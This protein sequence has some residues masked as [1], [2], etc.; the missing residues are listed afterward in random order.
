MHLGMSCEKVTRLRAMKSYVV[1]LC[2]KQ[3]LCIERRFHE[4]AGAEK[5]DNRI[6]M[7]GLRLWCHEAIGKLVEIP[8]GGHGSEVGQSLPNRF[9]PLAVQ[10][11]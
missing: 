4:S 9:T 2:A 11:R 3:V 7:G 6:G 1:R 8:G 10:R 5:P